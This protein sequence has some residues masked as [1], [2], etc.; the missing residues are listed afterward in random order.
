LLGPLQFVVPVK[1]FADPQSSEF[2]AQTVEM[3][4]HSTGAIGPFGGKDTL[5]VVSPELGSRY[6]S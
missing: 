3:E 2:E 4:E 6:W 1:N 5:F